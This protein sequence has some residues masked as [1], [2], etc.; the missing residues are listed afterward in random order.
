MREHCRTQHNFDPMPKIDKE[1]L[2]TVGQRQFVSGT[3]TDRPS[4]AVE[5]FMKLMGENFDNSRT[6]AQSKHIP[7]HSGFIWLDG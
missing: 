3:N 4:D 2:T 5:K 7:T 1:N 6:W